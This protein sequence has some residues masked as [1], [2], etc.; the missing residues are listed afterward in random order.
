[1][2]VTPS[3]RTISYD[4]VLSSCLDA[5]LG[6][7]PVDN[8][9]KDHVLLEI[10]KSKGCMEAQS[11]GERIRQPINNGDN[12]TVGSY[13]SYDVV[14]TTPQN[15]FTTLWY[16]WRQ[17]AA[18]VSISGL[19]EM[20]NRGEAAIFNLL[21]GKTNV[22]LQ[23]LREELNYQLLGKTVASGVWSAGAGKMASASGTDLDPIPMALSRDPTQSVA[24]GNINKN[25]Y[26]YWR[27]RAG[28]L[29]SDATGDHN[30]TFANDVTT[31]AEL[32]NYL[33]RL[34]Y[35]CS[36]G[37]GGRPDVIICSQAG[38]VG[39]EAA[40]R[41]QVRYT[42]QSDAQVAFDNLIF[43]QGCPMYW[44]EMM[45]DISNGY[46]HDSASY[47][48]ETF[49]FLNSKWMKLVYDPQ[50]NFTPTPFVKPENQD[51]K[52][53][54]LLFYGNLCWTQLRKHG[55]AYGYDPSVAA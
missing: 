37:G 2:A 30:S 17:L 8:I 19:E 15:E 14:D 41:T 29:D 49:Y 24:V 11:G 23:S 18:S 10:L 9:F 4:A 34:Y 7:D 5:F 31:Y 55:V 13:T 32:I 40:L 20:Q 1:M 26:S 48:K 6:T 35:Y 53:A 27:A 44:D 43:K 22:C 3:S 39:V 51:A 36:R 16:D 42:Q 54:L 47:A 28:D 33:N 38:F 25:T 12:S 45:P 52:T 50:H 46:V 21:K